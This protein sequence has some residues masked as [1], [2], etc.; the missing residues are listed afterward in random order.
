MEKFLNYFN[1]KIMKYFGFMFYPTCKQGKEE[2][3][4]KMQEMY[5]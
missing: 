5:K 1:K 2:R 3:N 4:K